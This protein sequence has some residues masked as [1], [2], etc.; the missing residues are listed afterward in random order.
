MYLYMIEKIH[1]CTFTIPTKR[2][3]NDYIIDI[4]VRKKLNSLIS[5]LK[6]VLL[7][8]HFIK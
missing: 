7:S 8:G 6:L 5:D 1:I 2:S 3:D 4:N